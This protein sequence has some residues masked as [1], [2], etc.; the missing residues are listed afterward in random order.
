[1]IDKLPRDIN[2]DT[3]TTYL[4]QNFRRN[5]NGVIDEWTLQVENIDIDTIDKKI[6]VFADIQFTS[7]GILQEY[8]FDGKRFIEKS[9]FEAVWICQRQTWAS[10]VS[11]I[12]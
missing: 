2:R 6:A 7:Q 5:F 10:V 8:V 9:N 12:A 3:L 11:L 4:E 1:M